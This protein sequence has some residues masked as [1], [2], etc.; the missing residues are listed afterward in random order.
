MVKVGDRIYFS[1]MKLRW[2]REVNAT[3]MGVDYQNVEPYENVKWR[4]F[5]I[6]R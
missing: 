6:D 3:F 4:F 2:M 5:R 1:W